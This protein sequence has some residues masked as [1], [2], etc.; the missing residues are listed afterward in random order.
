MNFDTVKNNLTARGYTVRCFATAREAAEYMDGQI[1]GRT[2]G[3]GGSVTLEQLG[4]YEK[5]AAHNRVHWHQRIPE[6]MTSLEVRELAKDTEIYVSSVNGLAE[7]GEIINIDGNGNRVASTYYGHEKI[8]LVAGRNKLAAD[9]EG[10]LWRARNIAAPRNAKRLGVN[11]PCAR[12]GDRCYD[13]DSPQRI[14][15][16]LSVFWRKPNSAA[17]EVILIDEDLGY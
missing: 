10:A 13:C 17:F 4:L 16:G 15:R 12:L 2:V 5:L 3:L 14:C 8:Y 9:L 11:T 1:D 7:S 6:G